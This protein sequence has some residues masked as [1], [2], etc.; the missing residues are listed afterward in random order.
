MKKIYILALAV[1][2]GG[3][4]FAQKQVGEIEK[5]V[6]RLPTD[7]DRSEDTLNPAS[8][9][10]ACIGNGLAL[11]GVAAPESGYLGGTNTY[12]DVGKGQKFTL[13]GQATVVGA[14][15][16]YGAIEVVGGAT[17][18]TATLHDDAQAL[19]TSATPHGV[20]AIDTTAGGA[21]GLYNY[22]FTGTPVTN[23]FYIMVGWALGDDTLGILSTTDP[24]GNDSYEVWSDLS[25]NDVETAWSGLMID[26]IITALVDDLEFTGLFDIEAKEFGI[27]QSDNNLILNSIS[28][29]VIM[30]SVSVYDMSGKMIKTFPTPDQFD[31]FSFD[32][33][34]V[35]AGNYI[36]TIDSNYGPL[37]QKMNLK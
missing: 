34:D 4:T 28:E 2:A 9:S 25:F 8:F 14:Q 36:V 20:S 23:D 1:M 5:T 37:S 7:F 31:N 19:L 26:F 24:C 30:K 12:G 6:D 22:A 35:N 27:Y 29:D 3:I 15:V 17:M 21:A 11:Y 13:N 18:V 16:V 33:S 32:I 10:D